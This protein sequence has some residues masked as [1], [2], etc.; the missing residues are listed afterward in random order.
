MAATT[1]SQ[2]KPRK[3]KN[4][5]QDNTSPDA[6]VDVVAEAVDVLVVGI[7]VLQCNLDNDERI[8]WVLDKPVRPS[9]DPRKVRRADDACSPPTANA[10]QRPETEGLASDKCIQQKQIGRGRRHGKQRN[11][12]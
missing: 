3:R 12:N 8:I 9:L 1:N 11:R 7:R 10:R 5:N 4:V 6:I 2:T